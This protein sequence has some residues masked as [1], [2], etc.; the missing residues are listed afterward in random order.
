MNKFITFGGLIGAI[1]RLASAQ[2]ANDA[3]VY[4]F[5]DVDCN[6]DSVQEYPVLWYAEDWVDFEQ[7]YL[8]ASIEVRNIG[9]GD[10]YIV[11]DS[12]L[13]ST[14]GGSLESDGMIPAG[15]SLCLNLK[16]VSYPVSYKL[17][18]G[19]SETNSSASSNSTGSTSQLVLPYN[20]YTGEECPA[21]P[22][23]GGNYVGSTLYKLQGVG[24]TSITNSN[25]FPVFVHYTQLTLSGWG[26]AY[27]EE[28][29]ANDVLCMEIGGDRTKLYV[30]TNEDADYT[31]VNS[32]PSHT[33]DLS[34]STSATT[35]GASAATNTN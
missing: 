6:E 27:T 2:V 31:F 16:N 1:A 14:G 12:T 34:P 30:D 23:Q 32:S 13:N 7:K 21:G 24:S 22:S 3:V 19:V 18:D 25:N 9:Y 15:V 33:I 11:D 28:I 17:I 4:L 26:G 5:D 35:D 29:G 20:A 10:L 8:A